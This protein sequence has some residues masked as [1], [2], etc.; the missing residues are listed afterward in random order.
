MSRAVSKYGMQETLRQ[1]IIRSGD[2]AKIATSTTRLA[3]DVGYKMAKKCMGLYK[4]VIFMNN[5]MKFLDIEW[6]TPYPLTNFE[7]RFGLRAS[8]IF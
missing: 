7:D 4:E 5:D 6:R 3:S 8:V 1:C 2:Y